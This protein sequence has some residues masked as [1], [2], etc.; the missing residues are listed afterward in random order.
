MPASE[1]EVACQIR[2]L[3]L[4]SV[5]NA[6]SE[7]PTDWMAVEVDPRLLDV[8]EFGWKV[9]EPRWRFPIALGQRRYIAH[10]EQDAGEKHVCE[11]HGRYPGRLTV[12]EFS[13]RTRA[14]ARVRSAATR[15]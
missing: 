11:D 4:N 8:L 9:F 1:E 15:G 13:G 6:R 14:N 12:S 2:W 7:L 3:G 5:P 10:C